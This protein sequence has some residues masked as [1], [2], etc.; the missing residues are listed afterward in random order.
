MTREHMPQMPSRQSES[1]ANGSS[2][3]S[4]NSSFTTSSISRK[5]MSSRTFLA[6]QVTKRPGLLRSFWRQTLSVRFIL[7]VA[8][9]AHVDFFV[10]QRFLVEDGRFVRALVFPGGRI[11]KVL[12]V[13]FGFAV[14]FLVLG[15]EMAA[16]GFVAVQ[17]IQAQQFSEL[18]EIGDAPGVFEALVDALD[19]AG[20]R[21]VLPE[22]LADLRD[23]L[24]RLL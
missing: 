11:S 15:S 9:G 22:F 16:A 5:D 18:H 12:V 14:R 1:K 6:S 13:A 8:A 17:R 19:L 20:D 7:L 21:E 3:R 24:Q 2:P 4:I 10:D 23:S